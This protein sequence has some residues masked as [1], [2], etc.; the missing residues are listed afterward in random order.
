M[1]H[2][3]EWICPNIDFGDVCPEFIKSFCTGKAIAKAELTVSAIGVYEA[4]I[5]GERVGDF[6]LAPGWTAYKQRLQYQTYDITEML[7]EENEIVI[8]V[9]KGWYGSRINKAA[10]LTSK[11]RSVI[12]VIKIDYADGTSE[13]I[14]TDE[15]WRARK[16]G[17]VFSDIY[18]GETYDNSAEKTECGVRVT[19]ED[20]SVLIPQEGEKIC[21]HERIKPVSYIVTPKGERVIDFG[22]EVT[23][24]VEFTVNAKAGETVEFS[25]AEVLDSEGNFY[26]ENY[27]SA[28]AKVRYICRDGVQAYKPHHTFFGFRYIRLDS[29][30]CEV[31]ADD[32]TAVAVYSDIKRTGDFSCSNKKINKLFSNVLW[33]QRDNYLDVPTDCPQRDERLG[34]TGDAQVFVKTAAYNFD[35][36][37]FFKKWINDMCAEQTENGV[38]QRIVPYP[39]I[40]GDELDDVCGSAAWCDAVTIV[41]WTLYMMYG[42][43][44]FLENSYAA[45]KKW[46]DFVSG[47]T[48]VKYLWFRGEVPHNYGDW[49]ALD[50]PD[51]TDSA[52]M[53][54][55]TDQNFIASAFYAYS[56]QLLV[57]TGNVLGYDMS[58]YE[59]LYKNIVSTVKKTFN[60][61][62][63]QTAC[64]LALHFDLTDDRQAVADKLAEMVKG[65]GLKTGFVGTP[66]LLHALSDNGHI[67]SAYDLLCCEEYPSWLYLVNK[68]ATTIWEHWDGI[69]E[70][71]SFWRVDM[72]SFNHYAY[73]A[74]MDWVYSKALGIN[75]GSAGFESVVIE[76]KPSKHLEWAQASFESVRGRISVKWVYENDG[77]RYDI[78]VPTDAE[79]II[80]GKSNKVGKGSY[81]F[82]GNE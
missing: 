17:I 33:G 72:N 60:T 13:I 71:G 65:C 38:I 51:T 77:V 19:D 44:E 14:N 29:Y 22:Q 45:M 31:N 78:T 37:K 63:T 49:L 62:N 56:T 41:P 80:D 58:E 3:A 16:T 66:Y 68:G 42:D 12:A 43:K 23:G 25:H 61:Y 18:D 55:D 82:Y 15:T 47:N 32:F 6:I 67:E 73:G 54:G 59:E 28:K 57:N 81:I 20:K 11:P 52:N 64:V 53:R 69:R 39:Y 76:P 34:W 2:S 35:V 70:D 21:E 7:S 74:V 75:P 1:I 30:P 9:G 4:Y 46:V 36:A 10:S 79:I 40:W 48:K 26:N 5:N 50:N 27:R 8:S 24:Y